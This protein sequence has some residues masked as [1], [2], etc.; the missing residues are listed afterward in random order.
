[1]TRA[2][3]IKLLMLMVAL[4]AILALGVMPWPLAGAGFDQRMA[5]ALMR[6]T[7]L[8]VETAPGARVALLPSPRILLA[9]AQFRTADR[10][11]SVSSPKIRVDLRLLPLFAGQVAVDGIE[12]ASPQIRL[13]I[14]EGA[15]LPPLVGLPAPSPAFSAARETPR[16]TLKDGSLFLL[17]AEGIRTI[18]RGMNLTIM[19][20]DPGDALMLAGALRWR[21]EPVEISAQWPLPDAAPAAGRGSAQP[22]FLRLISGMGSLRFEGLRQP[23][24]IGPIEGRIEAEAGSLARA[25][26]WIGESSPLAAIADRVRLTGEAV[27]A[28]S[29]L[30]L[31]ALSLTIDAD[32]LEG[33][34]LIRPG[35]DGAWGISATLAGSRLDFDRLIA[36]GNLA[37]HG[38]GKAVIDMPISLGREGWRT[39]DLRLSIE[40]A[41]LM[42]ARLSD[43][44]LQFLASRGKLDI[45][46]ARA[47]AYKGTVKG[48]MSLGAEGPD[49]PFDLRL[50]ANAERI[51]L[52]AALADMS[53]TRRLSGTGFLQLNLDGAG[54]SLQAI[55]ETLK[56]RASLVIRQ[57]ELT[58]LSLAEIARRADR[59]LAG[60]PRE[61]A[62]GRTAFDNLAIGGPVNDGVL[63]IAEGLVTGP[64]FRLTLGGGVNL[65][66]RS[67][68][69][70]GAL[71]GANPAARLPFELSGPWNQPRLLP[72]AEAILRRLAPAP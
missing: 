1:M 39:V 35:A 16:V 72:D 52:A 24:P 15:N 61:M 38:P 33:A 21:G 9:D 51:D 45:N 11:L 8:S 25:L 18:L 31:P 12:L 47:N 58:G 3:R 29:S 53:E 2:T 14:A 48:R 26:D 64:G 27:L 54:T 28:A 20:R 71:S 70:R 37:S 10:T 7:G 36:R 67:Y 13:T 50:S 59:P 43:V 34:A 63:D 6:A 17:G 19:D 23:G 68:Q 46:L 65:A 44:A 66:R 4:A 22:V 69:V 30:A 42:K 32:R 56:G 41:R 57:G 60:L 5:A 62:G 49:A 55:S 40:Q